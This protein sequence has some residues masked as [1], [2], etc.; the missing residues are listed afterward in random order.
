MKTIFEQNKARFQQQLNI[1]NVGP[2]LHY[3]RKTVLKVPV[4]NGEIE[5]ER[6]SLGLGDE[7]MWEVER[8]RL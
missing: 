6:K 2:L 4:C 8:S 1:W 5:R 7:S 3:E